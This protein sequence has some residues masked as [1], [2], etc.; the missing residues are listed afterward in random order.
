MTLQRRNCDPAGPRRATLARCGP[1]FAGSRS[2]R[3]GGLAADGN[4]AYD[5]SR[6]RHSKIRPQPVCGTNWTPA[7]VNDRK[8]PSTDRLWKNLSACQG[9][10]PKKSFHS[11]AT[12]DRR[13]MDVT[14]SSTP[15]NLSQR[16]SVRQRRRAWAGA[17]EK[18][19][20]RPST[21]HLGA[22]GPDLGARRRA[23]YGSTEH[24]RRKR[25]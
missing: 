10:R 5:P 22:A 3:G 7:R 2:S 25:T 16:T 1:L 23:P 21:G 15:E 11:L 4:F 9:Q 20:H 6:S 18:L 12:V 14:L 19:S 8:N 24:P 17:T 13:I